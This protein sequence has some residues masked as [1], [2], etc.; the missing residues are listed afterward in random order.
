MDICQR[1]GNITTDTV[2]DAGA[3][4]KGAGNDQDA[5]QLNAADLL[6][7]AVHQPML[8]VHTC[9]ATWDSRRK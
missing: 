6:S 5:S 9:R 7:D 4:G 1:G 2:Q 8:F 3:N